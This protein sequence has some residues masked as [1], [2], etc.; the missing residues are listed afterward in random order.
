MSG[1][2]ARRAFPKTLSIIRKVNLADSY[3]AIF[4]GLAVIWGLLEK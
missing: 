2:A 4:Y 1:G 3:L